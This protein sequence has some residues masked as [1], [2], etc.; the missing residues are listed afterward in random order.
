MLVKVATRRLRASCCCAV[1]VVFG[2]RAGW[3]IG[4]GRWHV[5][6]ESRGGLGGQRP[7]RRLLDRDGVGV[8]PSPCRPSRRSRSALP[9]PAPHPGHPMHQPRHVPRSDRRAARPPLTTHDPR[10]RLHLQHHRRRAVLHPTQAVEADSVSAAAPADDGVENAQ[11]HRRMLDNGSCTRPLE[12]PP[13]GR[14]QVRVY[15]PDLAKIARPR[16]GACCARPRVQRTSR[17]AQFWTGVPGLAPDRSSRPGGPSSGS[18]ARW[19]MR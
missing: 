15:A 2:Y 9:C 1:A 5:T 6:L 4:V 13:L 12:L 11:L 19:S 7:P 10:L 18:N 14:S 3:V 8:G 17:L 16:G